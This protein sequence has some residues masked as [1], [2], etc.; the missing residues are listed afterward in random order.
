M[1]DIAHRGYDVIIVDE[2]VDWNKNYWGYSDLDMAAQ[3][4]VE[5]FNPAFRAAK[6]IN[7]EIKVGIVEHYRDYLWAFMRAGGKPDFVSGEDYIDGW[8]DI[9]QAD[10]DLLKNTYNVQ[11]Q[12]WVI[13]VDKIMQYSGKVDL[14]IAADV[15]GEWGNHFRAFKYSD[16]LKRRLAQS[17]KI[18]FPAIAK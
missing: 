16:A 5:V 2:T 8:G 1:S 9:Q 14:V 13:G 7:P 6:E 4:A 15:R 10:L 12:Q 17:C 11:T 3:H 18:F